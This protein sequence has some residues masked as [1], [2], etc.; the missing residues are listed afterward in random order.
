[1]VCTGTVVQLHIME[2]NGVGGKVH[3]P[4]TLV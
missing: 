4:G 1:M 2:G 3:I